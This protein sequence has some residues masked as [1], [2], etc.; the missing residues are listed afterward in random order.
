QPFEK[1]AL[2]FAH[3]PEG[4]GQAPLR[5]LGVFVLS[6]GQR[7]L[8]FPAYQNLPT[9]LVGFRGNAPMWRE[10]VT[11]DHLSLERE[12][13]RW[14]ATT[15]RSKKHFGGPGVLDLGDDR[16]LWFGLSLAGASVLR[17]AKKET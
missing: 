9:Y 6:A 13:G 8:F 17:E 5:W 3:L 10:G 4:E 1:L 2:C 15:P 11:T 16:A 12:S 7:V 14:H